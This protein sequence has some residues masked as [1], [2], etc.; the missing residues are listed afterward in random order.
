MR[1]RT[2]G[3]LSIV[4]RASNPFGHR[5]A[6]TGDL[7]HLRRKDIYAA[8]GYCQ[9]V[10]ARGQSKRFD[11]LRENNYTNNLAFSRL[12][13]VWWREAFI[14]SSVVARN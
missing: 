11:Q 14:D 12:I 6:H 9:D 7:G 3:F 5:Q 8:A 10:M 4:V 2:R 1:R 13:R